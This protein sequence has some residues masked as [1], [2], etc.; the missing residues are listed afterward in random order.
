MARVTKA[1]QE[2]AKAKAELLAAG[3]SCLAQ[4]AVLERKKLRIPPS[5]TS[6]ANVYRSANKELIAGL[7]EAAKRITKAAK[8]M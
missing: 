6:V 5:A 4:V 3:K 8:E 1:M 7:K 2:H